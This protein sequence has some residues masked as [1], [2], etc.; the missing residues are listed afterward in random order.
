MFLSV[1]SPAGGERDRVR[2]LGSFGRS[3]PHVAALLGD[4]E[5]LVADLRETGDALADLLLC[6]QPEAQAQARFRGFAIDR[7]LRAGIERDPS[8]ERR[9]YQLAH[10][11]LVRQLHPEENSALRQPWL[12]RGAELALDGL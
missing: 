8:I 4:A 10:I 2:G 12:D 6:R 3:V 11:D 5:L 7:P 9:R 1:P